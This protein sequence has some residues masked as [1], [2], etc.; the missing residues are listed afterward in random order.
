MQINQYAAE[1]KE[2]SLKTFGPGR[3]TKGITKHIQKELQEILEDPEKSAHEWIDVVILGVDGYWR[4]GGEDL[5]TEI[6]SKLQANRLR[7]WPVP[8]SEDEPVEH[9][10]GTSDHISNLCEEIRLLQGILVD[11]QK[12]IDRLTEQVDMR[13]WNER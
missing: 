9:V 13:D 2:F 1:Q 12:I 11:K 7:T 3:R 6:N 8:S 10:G 5:D 4:H